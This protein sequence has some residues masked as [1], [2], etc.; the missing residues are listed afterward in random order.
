MLRKGETETSHLMRVVGR[1]V[2]VSAEAKAAFE[3]LENALTEVGGLAAEMAAA[4]GLRRNIQAARRI[5]D[6]A[7]PQLD[8]AKDLDTSAR[9][10]LVKQLQEMVNQEI[11]GIQMTASGAYAGKATAIVEAATQLAEQVNKQNFGTAAG[12]RTQL[13]TALV[14]IDKTVESDSAALLDRLAKAA[15]AARI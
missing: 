10:I 3:K 15:G 2:A 11:K 6:T 14:E 12:L 4:V 1:Q 5:L 8:K 7:G 9:G 13:T